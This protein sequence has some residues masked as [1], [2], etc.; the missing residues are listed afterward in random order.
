MA[1]RVVLLAELTDDSKEQFICRND[2][3]TAV[4][5]F[6]GCLGSRPPRREYQ[7]AYAELQVPLH[8]GGRSKKEKSYANVRGGQPFCIGICGDAHACHV[9]TSRRHAHKTASIP[10]EIPGE[11]L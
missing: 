9:I 3:H 10:G 8:D 4:V 5:M 7:T 11:T 2:E 6:W 1:A